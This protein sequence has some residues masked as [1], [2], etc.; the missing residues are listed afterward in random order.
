MKRPSN[1]IIAFIMA[2]AGIFLAFAL[3][4]V[5]IYVFSSPEAEVEIEEDLESKRSSFYHVSSELT[6][7]SASAE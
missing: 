3:G 1:L 5:A 2:I 6:N 4:R 7:Q